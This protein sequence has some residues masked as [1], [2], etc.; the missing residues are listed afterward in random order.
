MV[1]DKEQDGH[2]M[3]GSDGDGAECDEERL[4]G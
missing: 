2:G 3:V 1:T 4:C